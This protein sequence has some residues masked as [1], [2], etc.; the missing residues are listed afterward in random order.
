VVVDGVHLTMGGVPY[1]VRGATYGSFLARRDGESFPDRAVVQR[2]F[3]AMADAGLNTVRTYT[4]PPVDVLEAAAA[5]ELRVLVGLHYADWRMESGP[6]RS[7][8]RRIR[9]AGRRAVDEMLEVCRGNP[10]VLGIA[11]GNEVPVDL[12]RLHGQRAVSDVLS[13]LAAR[14]HEADP[15]LPVTYVNFPTTE[16]LDVE[17]QDLVSF[18]VFLERPDAFRRYLRHLLVLARDRPL[19]VT[20]LGLAAEVHGASA[21]AE[22]LEAQL[23]IVD[24]TGCAGATVFSWTDEWGVGGQP[25]TG[26]GF[27]LT[28]A[29]R[30]PKPALEVVRR[31][32]GRSLAATRPEWPS[33]SVVVCAYNEERTLPECLDSLARCE[34][35]HLEVIVCD[36][37]S[38]DGTAAVAASTPFRLLRLPHGGLSRAR[39]AG[40]AAATGEIVAYLDADAACHPEWPFHLARSLD[41]SNVAA[42]GGPNLPFPRSSLVERAVALSPGAPV[43]VLVTDDRAEHVP[44]CNMAFRREELVAIGGF[45]EAYTAA[46]DDVDVCWKLL[47]RGR[48]IAYAPTAQVHHHRRATLRG[49]LRQQRGYGR[50]DRMLSGAH[51]HR[52]NRLGQARWS[53]CMY[54]GAPLLPR[55]LRPTVYHGY[56]GMAPFQ[57]V[58]RRR[59]E[60]ATVWVGA[61]L[62]LSIALALVGAALATLS[63]WWL[64]LVVAAVALPVGYAVAVAASV[65]PSRHEPRP[66]ALALLVGALHALQPFARI[67]GRLRGRPLAAIEPDGEWSGE[68]VPWLHH[69]TRRLA[70]QGCVVRWARPQQ[71]WDLRVTVGPFVGAR[72]T[73][74]VLW[75]WQ[76][77]YGMSFR[78]RPVAWCIG[79][80]GIGFAAAGM[81]AGLVALPAMAVVSVGEVL[82]LRARVHRAVVDTAAETI[83][84][85]RT[86]GT[87]RRVRLGVP[88]K[89]GETVV[90]ED[91]DSEAVG[92]T[93]SESRAGA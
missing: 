72:L 79:A 5:H 82:V 69:L 44:G 88:A 25:V 34:Y 18:N 26:W 38:T 46:G 81:V 41:G 21:Q 10:A 93:A 73:T 71:P 32:A 90:R 3:A 64:L 84:D 2:D 36:D 59:A 52:F 67:W 83:S 57:P 86:D 39:N 20:E 74:A 55:L 1:R 63:P 14:I 80:L 48:A 89:D 37:G 66:V 54:G 78:A 50:A 87:R 92:G 17:G 23:G 7:A 40:L 35:P 8:Q 85:P 42:T 33:I 75:H 68:R 11:V 12:V 58:V 19:L 76:P 56:L 70:A 49:F 31:W 45:D 91:V 4:L 22:A 15:D 47:D 60:T 16:F 9:D 43:E 65:R 29:A 13:D 51:R 28:D 27:G 77:A 61:L 53:G 24:E 6:G 62:P 30:V